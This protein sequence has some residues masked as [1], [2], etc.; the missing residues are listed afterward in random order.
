MVELALA[1]RFG[2]EETNPAGTW[3]SAAPDGWLADLV[4]KIVIGKG[5]E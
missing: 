3:A 5:V 2:A 1:I 4:P